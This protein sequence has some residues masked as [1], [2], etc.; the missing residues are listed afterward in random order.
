MW[1][2]IPAK[3]SKIELLVHTL[4]ELSMIGKIEK[5]I[6]VSYDLSTILL[7][8]I[9]YFIVWFDITFGLTLDHLYSICIVVVVGRVVLVTLTSQLLMSL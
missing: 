9:C 7:S 2:K 1:S 6:R 5:K 8:R 3:R 4:N